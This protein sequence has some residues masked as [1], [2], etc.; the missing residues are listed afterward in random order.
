MR[1]KDKMWIPANEILSLITW[2]NIF[3]QNNYTCL[4]EMS[5]KRV[6]QLFLFAYSFFSVSQTHFFNA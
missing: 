5:F 3:I 2:K 6:S 4:I 1:V